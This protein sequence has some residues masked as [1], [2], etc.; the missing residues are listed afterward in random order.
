[1]HDRSCD[2]AVV[3]GGLAGTTAAFAFAKQGC[4]VRLFER[5]ELARDPNR[6]DLLHPPT[7]EVLDR[8]GL[9]DMIKPRTSR[10]LGLS[11]QDN[12]GLV[13][14]H[15]HEQPRIVLNHAEMEAAFLEAAEAEGAVDEN[16]AVRSLTRDGD[17]PGTGW[18][19]ETDEGTTR[20]RFLVGADGADSL[21]R[22]TLGIE[23]S[24][25]HEY[26]HWIVV[27]HAD[28]PQWLEPEHGWS[29]YHPDG[30]VFILPTTPE[31]RI[32]VIVIVPQGETKAWMTSSE[33]E[34]ARRL[35][36]RH[37]GL[38][39]LKLTK[40]GGS[41]VYRLKR[42]HAAKY[43]GPHVAL[44]GDAIHTTH[45]MGGQGLNIAIQD[46]AKLAELVGPLLQ[47]PNSTEA[48]LDAALEEYEEIRRPI[49]TNTLAQADWAAKMCG[50]GEA[51]YEFAR[52]FYRKAADD[53]G[54][55]KDFASRFGGKA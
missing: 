3:G 38:A 54:V 14:S 48:Q 52:D 55:M 47:D 17:E 12:E 46:S 32:R 31:G 42:S 10:I 33:E 50:P 4:S 27:L 1:M 49:N 29:L 25:V 40:R 6:G 16:H 37:P 39:E 44:V 53:P 23:Y 34:L 28:R 45:T 19:V 15:E 30:A 8:L 13:T 43:F 21:T 20:A 22:R 51:G 7:I 41:H 36:K 2:V 18:L 24:D 26:D 5:R 35:G 9:L 11:I